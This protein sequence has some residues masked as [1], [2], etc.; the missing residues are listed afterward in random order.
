MRFC[1]VLFK[2]EG[3]YG[4]YYPRLLMGIHTQ[5]WV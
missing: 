1:T 2:Y 4:Y 3:G 5:W